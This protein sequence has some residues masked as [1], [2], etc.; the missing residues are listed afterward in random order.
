MSAENVGSGMGLKDLAHSLFG[1]LDEKNFAN[2][3]AL[4]A[5][6]RVCFLL[7]DGLGAQALN[8]HAQYAPN[9][10][11][12][13]NFS[14][15]NTTFPS[16]T[17]TALAT[18]G[19]GEFPGSHG[20]LGYTV[21]VPHSGNPGRLINALKWDE[22]V[23][24]V[25]WQKSETLYEKAAHYGITSSYIA[26]KRYEGT[27]FTRA[28]LR[29]AKYL[30]ANR[31][32]EVVENARISLANPQSFS[33]L[34]VNNVDNAGHNDG[35]GS[36]KWIDA[37]LLVDGLVKDL[38]T[39]LPPGTSFYLSADHGMINSDD[40]CILGQ[41]NPLMQDVTLVGGE[42][43]ARHIYTRESSASDVAERYREFF[44]KKA[45]IYTKD[46]VV[47]LFGVATEH[48][49]E[50]M[51]DVIVVPYDNLLLIDPERVKQETSMVGHHGGTTPLEV[52]IPL[53]GFNL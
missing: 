29:G 30:G 35:V 12:L 36:Q 2:P 31:F 15:L 22:R 47:N 27:G 1:A 23:D 21:R 33:Y 48:A 8:K 6:E 41:E 3:L 46:D 51:G 4:P 38:L 49:T 16:T 50:R 43:R 39:V 11:A 18:L 44:G 32:D 10:A 7:V 37:L 28:T 17:A 24:P 42:P 9:L 13:Q 14:T 26:A 40:L 34:Y 53:L 5:T 52:E 19:T 45:D 25:L 20:M